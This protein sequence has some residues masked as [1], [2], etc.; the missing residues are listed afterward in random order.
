MHSQGNSSS[1]GSFVAPKTATRSRSL[2]RPLSNSGVALIIVLAFVVLLT[3]VVVA[4]FSRAMN[5]RGI[6]NSSAN[7]TKADLFAQGAANSIIGNL[8]QEIILNSTAVPVKAGATT[9]GTLYVPLTA[10]A[11]LPQQSGTASGI[12]NWAPTF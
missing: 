2:S 6:S 10:A 3:A 11:M 9:S 1:S 8:K 5:D 4:F 7:Q 12:T